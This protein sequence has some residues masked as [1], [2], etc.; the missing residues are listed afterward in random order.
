MFITYL[1]TKFRKAWL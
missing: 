1:Y